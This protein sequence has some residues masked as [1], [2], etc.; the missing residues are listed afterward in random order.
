[1]LLTFLCHSLYTRPRHTRVCAARHTFAP[2]VA[3]LQEWGLNIIRL[4][5][6]WPG[7]EPERGAYDSAYLA[8]ATQIITTA[9]MYNITTLV[10]CHQDCLAEQVSAV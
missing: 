8:A 1:M 10:D 7:V 6:M 9:A 4:G 2:C 5:V 3:A